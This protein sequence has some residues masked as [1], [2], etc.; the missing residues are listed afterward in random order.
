MQGDTPVQ[1][2]LPSTLDLR[3]GVGPVL[4]PASGAPA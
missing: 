2:L 4:L 1:F 3:V